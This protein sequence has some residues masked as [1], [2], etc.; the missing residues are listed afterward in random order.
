MKRLRRGRVLIS[1]ILIVTMFVTLLSNNL[2]SRTVHAQESNKATVTNLVEEAQPGGNSVW[3]VTGNLGSYDDWNVTNPNTVM[4]HLV[5]EYYVKSIKLDPGEYYFKFTKNGSW[6]NAIGSDGISNNSANFSLRLEEKTTIVFYL[7]DELEGINKVRTNISGLEEQGIKQYIPQITETDWPRL[8]GDLQTKLGDENNWSPD[9]SK[10]MFIDYYFDNSVYKLQRSLPTGNYECK[11][12][13]GNSWDK[14]NYGGPNGNLVLKI[15]DASAD[16]T[17]AIDRNAANKLLTHN[18]IPKDSNYDG[19]I[20]T[21]AL[22]YNSQSITY[23]RPFGAIKQESEDV[24]FRLAT[25]AQDAQMVKL[26]LI[27]NNDVSS[28]YDM[29]IVTVLDGKDYWE[30]NIPKE[31]FKEIGVWGYKFIIIDGASKYEYGDDGLS[32]GTG[33]VAEEGQT[34]YNLTVYAKDYTTPNWMKNAVVYQIFPDRFYD[35]D[36][37][38]NNAKAKDG[39]RGDGVQLFDGEKWATIPENPRQS[40]E[41]NKPYYPDAKTDGVWSNEF[42]GGD[43]KG[44]QDKLSYLKTLGVTAIYL[45]PVSWAASNHKYDATDYKH[46]DP[47]FGT[48]VYNT[49]GNPA[50]GLNYEKT[51]EASDK[52]YQNFAK[53]C[54]ELDI[55]LIADGVFNHVGD[56]SIYFDRYE[57]Y[58]EIGA[59]EYWSKVWNI[60]ETKGVTQK[61]AEAQVKG[62][63]KSQINPTTGKKYSDADF[64]Y[65]NW[66]KVGP[67]K[68]YNQ[69]SGKFERYEYE[70]WWGYDSLPVVAAVEASETK[71]SNNSSATIAG[72]HEYNN[73][74]FRENVIGYDLNGANI[75][76]DIEAMQNAN[77][78]RWLWM[79]SSGWRLDVAP[80]VSD[81][82]WR[83]FRTAV[84]STVGKQDVNGNKI[85][86]PVILGEEWGVAT[87]YLLGD[88]FDSVMNYQFRAAIQKFIINNG[89]ASTLNY[90][91]EVIR[92]NY[93]KEAWQAML[94]LVD[95]HDTV[96]N[97]TKIDNPGWEE[98]NIKIAPDA[99]ERAI[100]LQALT[101]IFQLS[102]PG[103]PTIYYGDEVGVTGTKDPDSRRTFPWERVTGNSTGTYKIA[104]AFKDTYGDLF[105]SYVKASKVRNE[106][107]ELFATGDIKTA[108]AK[109]DTIAY[110]RRSQT[111]G[112]LTVINKSNKE[113]EV[114]ADVKDFLPDG[115]ELRDQLGTNLSGIVKNG[116]IMIKVPALTGLMMVST[117]K[118][119]DLPAAPN[120]LT[121]T[122]VDG[123]DSYVTLTWD[124]VEGANG[125]NVYRTLLDGMETE[126]INSEPIKNASYIDNSVTNGTRYYYYVKSIVGA[127][128]S[129]YSNVATALPSY[130]I[131]EITTPTKVN[132]MVIGVGKKT[133]NTEVAITIPGLTD[134]PL[135]NQKDIPAL[136]FYLA[137]YKEGDKV[138]TANKTKLRYKEDSTDGKGKIYTASFEPTEEGTYHYFAE[139]SVNNGYTYKTSLNSDMNAMLNITETEP[140]T[141]VLE[142]P[143]QEAGRVSLNWTV[144]DLEHISGYEIY[145]TSKNSE[146]IAIS[147]KIAVLEKSTSTYTDFMVSNDTKYTYQVVAFNQEYNRTRSNSVDITPKLT[148]VDVTIRLTIPDKVF[149]SATDNI[150]IAGDVNGW[151][152]SGWLMKKPSGATDNNIVEYSFKMMSGKKI[153]YKYTRGSWD[154]EALTSNQ[155]NDTT[156]PGNYGYSSTDTNINLTITNQGNNKMLVKDY[157]LRW[158]DMPIMITV[159]RISY[160]GE[161][162]EYTTTEN[163][164]NL[165]AS[166]PYGGI[167]TMNGKDIN[168]ISPGALDDYGNVRL[169]NIP[170]RNGLNQFVLHI[171]PTE[172]TKSKS[173]LTDTGR[174]NSQMT[175]TT[176]IKI[177][178]TNETPSN[179]T[180]PSTPNTPVPSTSP[181]DNNQ[182]EPEINGK[183]GSKG[184][185]AIQKELEH[186]IDSLREGEKKEASLTIDMNSSTAVPKDILETISGKNIVLILNYGS[187]QWSILG[188][189]INENEKLE[190]IYDLKVSEIT[191]SKDKSVIT[192]AVNAALKRSKI[193]KKSVEIQQLDIAYDGYFPFTALLKMQVGKAY[194]NRYVYL[195]YYNEKTKKLSVNDY[196]KVD[197]EGTVTFTFH[198]TSSYVITSENPILP[199]VI[200]SKIL[201]SGSKYQLKVL[202]ALKDAKIT[203]STNKKSVATVDK[204]G[205]ITAKKSGT[206]TITVKVVQAGKTYKYTTK[207]TVKNNN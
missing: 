126:Q 117:T 43:I 111:E 125:Y 197:K 196:A 159:P 90:D 157:V 102:Y 40:E 158:V 73:V 57:K 60:V 30:V 7:N 166:V 48:P 172:E 118:L 135:Y 89:D 170:L 200:S 201:Y 87:D 38:N 139:A 181:K 184:W 109:D 61:E 77:S 134:A 70:G 86:E 88:M 123:V 145:R 120:N 146:D 195:N 115:L 74:N 121:A 101:A 198:H 161:T 110:G 171:E 140:A 112:G 55:N 31:V 188:N 37:S 47:M 156:S 44:I 1:W 192:K 75:T 21:T 5:G 39:C 11:V 99:S 137:Y 190:S 91:L 52:V 162:I 178:K 82:T 104:D 180:N 68:I 165:Q 138:V 10:Q 27:D 204:F 114:V 64:G 83:Q 131:T 187:Y 152:A 100:K 65:I 32:G 153:Q 151:N 155:A 185:I 202:D 78:Q 13:F 2:V 20:D 22:Y 84:K 154:K 133:D 174:I 33:A 122:A 160:H 3:R 124:A 182:K 51:K 177:T 127:S 132:D 41:A 183:D 19:M 34:P 9:M 26:E 206:A 169:D 63:F 62:Y 179:P 56:D 167:F 46:L 79:G 189:S 103:A 116:L 149:T 148:M 163:S 142:Q 186:I 49:P 95:S 143:V 67:N 203:Y 50:S 199:S 35:G 93:P 85:K 176:V 94:N 15:L 16:V 59:Y 128:N 173:W 8:V 72:S 113:V 28:T 194:R 12:V 105:Q 25:K 205:L 96:R 164:F 66:F 24:T 17:F 141:P 80:D 14:E 144:S 58:P 168:S 150:Y 42:Y 53:V 4:N 175:A 108:F 92:E 130:E 45:N 193:T 69:I 36:S 119:T 98:E 136:S 207:V 18:Y 71:L 106:H 147:Y 97:I 81:D 107:L 29:N 54:N 129:I 23:K 6:D 191:D 76:N